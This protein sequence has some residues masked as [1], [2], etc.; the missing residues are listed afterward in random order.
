MSSQHEEPQEFASL[1]RRQFVKTTAATTL[2][3]VP[4]VHGAGSDTIRVGLIG[5][6]GR[7]T[8]AASQALNADRGVVV[9][10]MGDVFEGRVSGSLARLTKQDPDRVRVPSEAQFFGFDAY[11]KVIDSGVDVVILATPP[12]FRPAH[13]QAAVEAGK[14]VFT[15]KPM[16]VDSAGVRSVLRTV[17]EARPRGLSIVAGFCWRYSS[18]ERATY[19]RIHDGAVG[20][21]VSVH[22]T[23]HASPLGAYP[24][25]EGWSDME[26][27]LR[28]WWHFRWLSGDHIV[29]QACHSIDKIN[30]AMGDS[31]PARAGAL[32]G[33]QMR[34]GPESGNVYDHFT[35]IYEYDDGARCFHT[36]RQMPNCAYDNTDYIMGTAGTCFVNGWGPTHVIK[37]RHPWVY[38]GAHPNMYQVEHDELFASIRSGEP[39]NDGVWMTRS[40]LMAIMG[41]MAAYSGQSVTWDQVLNA[42]EDWAPQTYTLSGLEVPPVAVPGAY[43]VPDPVAS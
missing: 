34:S 37:G 42:D 24:R 14:H 29:E 7:G 23:Y 18:P 6:G 26:W 11:R 20:D 4:F 17:E 22:T 16:A 9:T 27:Q 30:W 19:G 35:V 38:E 3:S 40:T 15:E 43:T 10:A 36:C 2:L 25:Q 39:I 5:C 21:V 31:P 33:R 8:G 13:L 32:G 28:N 41:R 12:H 1:S